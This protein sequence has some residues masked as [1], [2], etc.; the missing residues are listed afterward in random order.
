MIHEIKVKPEQLQN[1]I[2]CRQKAI[3]IHN[4]KGFQRG[5]TVRIKD[6]YPF[7][8]HLFEINHVDSGHGIDRYFVVLSVTYL[9][10]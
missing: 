9:N 4:D 1:L 6:S 8:E 7:T 5:D 10:D 3:V 2:D